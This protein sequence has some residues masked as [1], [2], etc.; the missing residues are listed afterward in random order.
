MTDPPRFDENEHARERTGRSDTCQRWR[1]L[2]V[3]YADLESI[4]LA[5][6]WN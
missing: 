6:L 4:N 1:V 2:E 3:D 5:E